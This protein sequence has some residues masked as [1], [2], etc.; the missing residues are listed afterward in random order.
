MQETLSTILTYI[1]EHPLDICG[2]IAGLFYIW[3]QYH[4]DVRLW[5]AS[6]IMS[7]FYIAIY[8]GDGYYAMAGV[9]AYYLIAAI[10]GIWVWKRNSGKDNNEEGLLK[11]VN[12]KVVLSAIVVIVLISYALSIILKL[13]NETG[14]LW[15]DAITSACSIVGMWLIAKKYVEHWLLWIVVDGLAAVILFLSG[16]YLSCALFLFYAIVSVFGYIN[17]VKKIGKSH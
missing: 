1:C 17:W 9:Y 15:M 6:L 12:L 5:V 7:C 8:L 4:V 11:H 10:Y 13:L 3:Y 14:N 16:Q 2:T